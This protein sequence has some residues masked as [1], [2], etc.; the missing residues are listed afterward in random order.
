M[1]DARILIIDDDPD[2]VTAA[3]LL[4]KRDYRHIESLDQP[5][6]LPERLEAGPLDVIL[7]DM[8]FGPGA[9][10]GAE[11]LEWIERIRAIDPDVIIIMI[12]A[13][14]GLATAVEAM[15]RGANDF[16][17][18]PW[19]NE[20]LL[21]TIANALALARSRRES[22][23]LRGRTVALMEDA[24][25]PDHQIIG[26]SPEMAQVL[27]RITQAGPTDAN[28]L[29]LGENGVGKELVARALHRASRR[30][31]EVFLSV[32]CGAIPESLFESEMFGHK[33][34][35]FT[36]A[37]ADRVGRFEAASGGTL[38]LDEIGN[39]P[40]GQQAK[41]LRA[42][43]S[44]TIMPLGARRSVSIDVRLISATNIPL[45][46]LGDPARFRSDL[47]FRLNT[48]EIHLPPL[49][50]RRQDIAPLALHY[51]EKAE[52]HYGKAPKPLSEAARAHLMAHDWPGNVRALRHAAERAVIFSQTDHYQPQDFALPHHPPSMPE[53]PAPDDLN[54]DRLERQTIKQALLQHG[55]NISRAAK[56]LGLTR[57]ALYRRMEKH[58]L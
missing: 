12:T 29:L 16:I 8:N 11:G 6:G 45:E 30:A 52:R 47:Y 17:S 43:E 13:H 31:G 33:K 3:R 56:A 27:K 34:G 57:A 42:L 26:D 48:I 23:A 20:R 25:R 32:D 21:A 39:L 28:V 55:Y 36:G 7:L 53:H 2:I 10:S 19:A 14:G 24:A 51:L 46:A 9:S 35:A 50:D 41:L 58:G 1:D 22:L 49:R 44:R 18:K 4:L 15:K 38:F 40:L 37:N 5:E 54:L